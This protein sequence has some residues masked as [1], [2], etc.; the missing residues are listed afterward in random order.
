MDSIKFFLPWPNKTLSPNSR[1]HWSALAKAKKKAKSDAYYLALEAGLGKIE[2]DT[3]SVKLT[4]YPPS[5]RRYDSDNLLAQH[6]GAIDGISQAIGIDDSKFQIT[7]GMAGVIEK[8]GMVKVEL[9][10]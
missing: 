1:V 4:F 3:V 2:A 7:F 10:W 9:S 5:K 8:N 6:K